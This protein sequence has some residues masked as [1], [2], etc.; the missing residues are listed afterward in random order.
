MIKVVFSS[1]RDVDWSFFWISSQQDISF[2]IHF[3]L[4][5]GSCTSGEVHLQVFVSSSI[6]FPPSVSPWFCLYSRFPGFCFSN[7]VPDGGNM[8]HIAC[9]CSL[10]FQLLL[11][12][13]LPKQ[14][15]HLQVEIHASASFRR[16]YSLI[17]ITMISNANWSSLIR[18]LFSHQNYI[19]LNFFPCWSFLEKVVQANPMLWDILHAMC[20]TRLITTRRTKLAVATSSTPFRKQTHHLI[21]KCESGDSRVSSLGGAGHLW[22]TELLMPL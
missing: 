17:I 9:C 20:V 10:E 2:L 11:I 4:C 16:P 22:P 7:L 18:F 12:N 15:Y 6:S 3:F 19:S 1:L 14:E 21:V 13:L 8:R 5:K